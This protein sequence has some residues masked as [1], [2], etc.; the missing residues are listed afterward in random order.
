[1]QETRVRSPGQEDKGMAIHSSVLAWRIPWAEEPGGLQ[2]IGWQRV[3]H[4]WVTNSLN[5]PSKYISDRISKRGIPIISILTETNTRNTK[6]WLSLNNL[7]KC[8]TIFAGLLRGL[9]QG[10]VFHLWLIMCLIVYTNRERWV[11]SIYLKELLEGSIILCHASNFLKSVTQ[12]TWSGYPR[13]W[14]IGYMGYI[15]MYILIYDRHKNIWLWSRHFYKVKLRKSRKRIDREQ[16]TL[17]KG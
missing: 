14:V 7:E 15:Y 10:Q 6:W 2:S 13:L 3:R 5:I 11:V 16:E 12:R 4:N 9:A 1:M 8:F 17:L